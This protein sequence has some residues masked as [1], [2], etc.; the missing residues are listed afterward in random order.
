MI[1]VPFGLEK[2]EFGM[3]IPTIPLPEMFQ[4]ECS[5]GLKCASTEN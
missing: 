5:L 4:K 3:P 1:S 2:V